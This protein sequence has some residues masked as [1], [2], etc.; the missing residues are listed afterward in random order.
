MQWEDILTD[1]KLDT[2]ESRIELIRGKGIK[3]YPPK[4]CYYDAFAVTPFEQVKV[5]ILG[6]DPYHGEGQAN[7]LAFSVNKGV[8]LPPSLKNIYK[9]LERDIG[10]KIPD[11]GDLY[12]WAKEG[13][14]LLNSE[15]T[16]NEGDP[17]SHRGM[18]EIE[19]T[20][21]LTELSKRGGVVFLLWGRH[22]QTKEEYLVSEGNLILKAAH[23]SPFSA[24]KG[25]FGCRHFSK[26]NKWLKKNGI[27]PVDW[28]MINAD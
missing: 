25:F 24:N 28:S 11:H 21:A 2:L 26:A 5:V 4:E 27:E 17:G 9:E 1:N 22:A 12:N 6:Q 23:P 10:C 19:T 20:R 13:V 3:V 18:W 16:V 7:G 14:L 15:L 8:K